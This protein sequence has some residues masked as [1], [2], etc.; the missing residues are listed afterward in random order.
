MFFLLRVELWIIDFRSE[1][2][3]LALPEKFAA[4]GGACGG[5]NGCLRQQFESAGATGGQDA[6]TPSKGPT[7]KNKGF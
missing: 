5:L 1:T 7:A 6:P 2:A 3:E 4:S